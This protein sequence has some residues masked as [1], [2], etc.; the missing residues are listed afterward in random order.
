[1]L[2]LIC[3]QY[4]CVSEIHRTMTWTTE[5]LT[6]PHDLLMPVYAHVFCLSLFFEMEWLPFSEGGGGACGPFF[7]FGPPFMKS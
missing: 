7:H 3:M 2:T 4:L 6:C 1:M 5:S